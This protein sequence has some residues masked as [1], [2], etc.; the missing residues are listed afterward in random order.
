MC[1]SS[2]RE[3]D[4]KTLCSGMMFGAWF[5]RVLYHA[6]AIL[7]CMFGAIETSQN[8]YDIAKLSLLQNLLHVLRMVAEC[9]VGRGDMYKSTFSL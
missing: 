2:L 9:F 5:E 4:S 3:L 6:M 8:P 1:A 7:V